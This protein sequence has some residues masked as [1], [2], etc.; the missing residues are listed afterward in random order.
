[1]HEKSVSEINNSISEETAVRNNQETNYHMKQKQAIR[2]IK[3]DIK[4]IWLGGKNISCLHVNKLGRS[5]RFCLVEAICKLYYRNRTVSEF[6]FTI[7]KV[8]ETMTC[9][10]LEEK[11]FIEYYQLPVSV[12][13][14]NKMVEL[15]AFEKVFPQL[16]SI[17]AD[18]NP[19]SHNPSNARY[20]QME[21]QRRG[22]NQREQHVHTGRNTKYKKQYFV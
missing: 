5:G 11:A 1:M 17:L 12:L 4:G 6:L 19:Q 10:E 3:S 20:P 18:N 13:K 9:T 7:E 16:M 15:T 14:C 2:D 8:L 22:S 21:D